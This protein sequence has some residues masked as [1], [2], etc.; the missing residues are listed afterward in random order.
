M[1]LRII[2]LQ[3]TDE[4]PPG[5]ATFRDSR[6]R[7]GKFRPYHIRVCCVIDGWSSSD[8]V[9]VYRDEGDEG[10]IETR[11]YYHTSLRKAGLHLE[12]VSVFEE[13]TLI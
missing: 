8:F 2:L 7:V 3:T 11:E 4:L 13:Y 10:T 6:R 12:E 9:L 1:W 5:T